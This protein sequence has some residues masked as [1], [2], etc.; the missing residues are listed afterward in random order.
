M[1][2]FTVVLQRYSNEVSKPAFVFKGHLPVKILYCRA[3]QGG[4]S[5]G[6]KWHL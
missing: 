3:R 4:E 6:H 5:R 2:T 1:D